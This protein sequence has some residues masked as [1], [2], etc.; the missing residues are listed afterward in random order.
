MPDGTQRA[1]GGAARVLAPVR[2]AWVVGLEL[3]RWLHGF[4]VHRFMYWGHS[5]LMILAQ[6]RWS[7]RSSYLKNS[8]G[9]SLKLANVLLSHSYLGPI[10]CKTVS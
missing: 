2:G 8:S 7:P 9:I 6:S 1:T 10:R 4:S 5:P 3:G